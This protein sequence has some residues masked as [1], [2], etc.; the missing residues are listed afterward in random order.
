MRDQEGVSQSWMCV[1]AFRAACVHRVNPMTWKSQ[2]K[3]TANIAARPEHEECDCPWLCYRGSHFQPL[4]PLQS[5][6]KHLKTENAIQVTSTRALWAELCVLT[7]S[8]CYCRGYHPCH[9]PC[10]T[11][12]ARVRWDWGH[13]CSLDPVLW[14]MQKPF[15]TLILAAINP[16]PLSQ[17][18]IE[19]V[20]HNLFLWSPRSYSGDDHPLKE[21]RAG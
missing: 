19:P 2:P 10:S 11:H 12:L 21:Q 9:C 18:V 15:C 4:P 8:W 13:F 6:T 7:F 5:I 1:L 17:A 20:W 16:V 3:L 14:Q